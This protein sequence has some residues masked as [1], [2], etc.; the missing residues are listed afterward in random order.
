M[1]RELRRVHSVRLKIIYVFKQGV[2]TD[3]AGKVLVVDDEKMIVKGIKFSL[4]QD[5][6]VVDCAYDGEEALNM[7]KNN[8][9]DIIL[10][11]IMLPKMN[12]LEVC[13]QIREFSNVP[14][15]MLTAKGDDMD[16]IM[17]LEYGADDY[18][19]KPFNILEVKSRM[20]AILRRNNSNKEK[21]AVKSNVLVV[22]DMKI[23]CD[24]RSLFIKGKEIYLTAKEFD[25]LELLAFNP[26]RVYSRDTLLKTV[27]GADYPGDGRTVDVHIR[28]LREKI[29]DNS[30]DPKYVHTKWGVGYYFNV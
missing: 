15:I 19:T 5:Y 14:I 29:E 27:W 8:D 24:S 21:E 2:I 16:K 13:Q 4:I 7:A 1:C 3:M 9:Y 30:S 11:D 25:L 28:R 26:N 23:D 22:G 20:K 10:L 18:I 17:G 12:G 6:S